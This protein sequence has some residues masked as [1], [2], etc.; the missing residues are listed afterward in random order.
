MIYQKH[1][2]SKYDV[3]MKQFKGDM[4]AYTNWTTTGKH[5]FETYLN[6]QNTVDTFA[7]KFL[8]RNEKHL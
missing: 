7:N 3:E 2:I 5:W 1:R 8:F 6:I 4:N